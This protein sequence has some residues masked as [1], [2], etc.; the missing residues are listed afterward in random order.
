MFR[1]ARN[2]AFNRIKREGRQREKLHHAADWL[3]QEAPDAGGVDRSRLLA[4]ALAHLPEKQRTVVVL[5]FFMEKT[6]G[7][8]G[9]IL[10]ISINTAA[11]RLRYGMEKLKVLLQEEAS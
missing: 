1:L 11:S 4:G 3:E 2:A 6:L 7:E 10:H 5:K 8:I 9:D